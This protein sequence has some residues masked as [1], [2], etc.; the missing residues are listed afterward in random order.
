MAVNPSIQLGTSGNWAI[1]EDNLLAY[2]QL[3]NKFFDRE[4]DFSRGTSA[5]Y[6]ARDGLIK[7]SDLQSTNLVQN[8][9][10]SELGSEL[11]TNGDF[12]TD[13]DWSKGTGWSIGEGK[14]VAT[15]SF[16]NL[17]QSGYSF[18]AGNSYK[19]TYEVL[20]YVNG[21][22]I[23]QLTGG[24]TLNG[25]TRNT[26]GTF[27]QYVIAT[28]NH[29]TFRFRGT[30]FTGSIDNVSVKEVDPN[31]NW[32]LGTGWSIGT[33]KATSDAS[34]SSY[35]N[36][37]LYTIGNLYKLKFEVLEGTIELRSAQYSKGVGYYTTGTHEIEVIPTTTSTHFYVYTGFG[38]SSITNISVIEI[39]T[40]VPRIDFTDDT[41][42][43]L[44][45]EP[46]STNIISYSEDFSNAYWAKTDGLTVSYLGGGLSPDG[47]NNAD[48]ITVNNGRLNK[49]LPVINGAT[50]TVSAYY[51]GALGE[52]LNLLNKAITLT[53]DWQRESITF[54]ATSTFRGFPIIDNRISGNASIVEVWGAQLEQK[55]YPT[56]YI[57]T[58]GSAVTRN[59]EICNN[60][61]TVNDFNSEEG[62][63][64]AEIAY[65]NQTTSSN[66]RIAI[67]DGTGSNRVLIQNVSST[68]NRLQFYVIANGG[69]STDF[70]TD[71]SDIT[72]FN[73]IAFKYKANDFSVWINGIEILTDTSGITFPNGI[74]TELAFDGG[75]GGYNF[76]GKTKN[77]KVFKRA[78]TDAELYL[79]TVTQY[80]SYQEMATA[81]NYTL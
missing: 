60:S 58:S 34:V 44:L 5:T 16:N 80:Q 56:S 45:L 52:T 20:D 77:L 79:L 33:N 4:F 31:D 27:T 67:S 47:V 21:N 53:G 36:Q 38:Q 68:S 73:K 66:L 48:L 2:K 61:G 75:D 14:A 59:Q 41:T 62:V 24:S 57:P 69:T 78:L 76:Y 26:N 49:D 12:A 11:V 37:A 3:G 29:T 39:Q 72:L 35:L 50:Y 17:A 70:Y 63:L 55:S 43:H 1:K 64:Y 22:I 32:S 65:P 6:V 25:D 54:T 9:N 23:F 10:F 81:L 46:Q 40:D 71:L 28:D 42:G 30:N 74:L 8:G 18:V 15:S 13:S 51:K 7:T 19:V